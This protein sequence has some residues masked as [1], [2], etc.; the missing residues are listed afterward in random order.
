MTLFAMCTIE[1]L[2]TEIPPPQPISVVF[3]AMKLL[4]MIAFEN[5][6]AGIDVA[7][8]RARVEPAEEIDE[9]L[10]RDGVALVLAGGDED[11]VAFSLRCVG[12]GVERSRDARLIAAGGRDVHHLRVSLLI[13]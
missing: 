11:G 4:V 10:H 6:A 5:R 8:P 12:D 2:A 1:E 9:R 13:D 3:A 7:L